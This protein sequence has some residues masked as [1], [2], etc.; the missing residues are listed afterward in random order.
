MSEYFDN[1]SLFSHPKVSQYGSHVVM[2]DVVKES[3][4][5]YINIDT[6][7]CD[8]YV[9]NRLKTT[10]ADY[11]L[12]NFNITLPER[13][14]DVK[15]INIVSAEIPM[16]FFNISAAIGN[17]YFKLTSDASANWSAMIVIPD[18]QYTSSSLISQLN[19]IL[20]SAI[21]PT[22]PPYLTTVDLS[23]NVSNQ[24]STFYLAATSTFSSIT[25]NFAVNSIGD[26]DKYHFKSKLGW[27]LGFRNTTYTINAGSTITSEAILN[28]AGPKYLYL[29]IDEYSKGNQMSFLSALPTYLIN[30]NIIAK[31]LLDAK[32]Y[33]FGYNLIANKNIGTLITEIRS[34]SGKVDLQKLNVQLLD[35][36]G[37]LVNLN[38]L[39]FSFCIEMEYE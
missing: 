12:A 23:Y 3:R 13:I 18:G 1:K 39:D 31:I 22:N 34:Y 14:M 15:K 6:K 7:F 11:N 16:S 35:E 26:F 9:N 10:A 17:N 28:L 4:V 2:T 38:G 5:K 36:N 29:A 33:P 32:N 20:T 27:L 21:Y 30:K 37:Q 19:T 8:D 24:F 25:L